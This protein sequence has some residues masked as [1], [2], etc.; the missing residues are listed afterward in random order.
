MFVHQTEGFVEKL[1]S[2]HAF[3]HQIKGFVEKPS[4]NHAFVHRLRDL[5]EKLGKNGGRREGKYGWRGHPRPR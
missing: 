4:S 1:S 3:V 5:V 2:N